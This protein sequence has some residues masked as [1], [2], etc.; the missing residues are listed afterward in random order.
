MR[1]VLGI[2]VMLLGVAVLGLWANSHE[3]PALQ[4]RIAAGAAQV[5]GGSVHGISTMVSGRDINIAGLADS[6]AERDALM[7]ALNDVP[8]RRV[9]RGELQLLPAVS[10]FETAVFKSAEG[11]LSASGH[12]PTE[13]ARALLTPALGEA[14]SAL[15]LASG[16]PEGQMPA[17][18]AG[19][20]ALGPTISGAAEVSDGKLHV[21][22]DV[23]GP[24]ERG[25]VL[26]ALAGLP[27]G[28]VSLDLTLRDDGTPPDWTLDYSAM[29]GA[30]LTGKL[31][32]GLEVAAVAGALGLARIDNE[33][34]SALIGEPMP[35]VPAIF[36]ILKGWMADFERLRVRIGP[37]GSRIEAGFGAGADRELISG[38][39]A[40]ALGPDVAL[41]IDVVESEAP[42][43]AERMNAATGQAERLSA[44]YWLPVASFAADRASCQAQAENVLEG[45]TVNFVTGSDRLDADAQR[46]LNR[47]AAVIAPCAAV[48]LKAEIGGHTDASGDPLG[49]IALSQRRAEAV[50]A[51]LVA[52]GV[53]AAMLRAWGYGASRPVADNAT[54]EGRARNRRTTV[55]WSE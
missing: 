21:S 38:R 54:D 50:R 1:K 2:G 24:G 52:R 40:E 29:Q 28:A 26:L 45:T 55:L 13:K 7:A 31:P 35:E 53:P 51:A 47:L 39:L 17:V 43:G 20:A 36:G 41:D 5:A 42:E 22:G 25:A 6:A 37:G 18:I 23:L 15:V 30:V 34:K 11:G 44:G 33:A 32:K 19:I 4:S 10:P 14:A 46:V 49:N 16:A 3:A 9:V 12:V 27:E 8:G 48:G